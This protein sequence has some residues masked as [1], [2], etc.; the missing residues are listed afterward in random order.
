MAGAAGS[1]SPAGGNPDPDGA[2]TTN[3]SRAEKPSAA[4]DK[5]VEYDFEKAVE[6]AMRYS[7]DDRRIPEEHLQ[8]IQQA[9]NPADIMIRT[10]EIPEQILAATGEAAKILAKAGITDVAKDELV[11][12]VIDVKGRPIA[13]VS[14]DA[15]SWYPGNETT[16]N[17]QG[18]FRLK[19]LDPRE[20]VQLRITKAGYSPRMITGRFTG[21]NDSVIILRDQTFFEGVVTGVDN[22]PIKGARIVATCGPFECNPGLNNSTIG[23]VPL[24]DNQR[25]GWEISAVRLSESL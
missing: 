5:V 19:E 17:E 10:E 4:T 7:I 25:R 9:K 18:L 16:T 22:R 8:S 11:G 23:E 20:N 21:R 12:I 15:W 13:G 24:R 14:V 3:R 1:N 2:A 6:S